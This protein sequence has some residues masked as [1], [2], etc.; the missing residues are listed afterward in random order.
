MSADHSSQLAR[1]PHPRPF[2]RKAGEGRQHPAT[3]PVAT[4]PPAMGTKTR[5]TFLWMPNGGTAPPYSHAIQSLT[6]FTRTA[7][8]GSGMGA[9]LRFGRT[10]A[11]ITLWRILK[12]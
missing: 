7:G 6:P 5:D 2:P 8:E 12:P 9:A 10:L 1:G 3:L 4:S 11:R